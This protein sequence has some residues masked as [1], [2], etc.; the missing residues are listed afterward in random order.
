ME[1]QVDE[2][3]QAKNSF[4]IKYFKK[5]CELS[6]RFKTCEIT[7]VPKDQNS[8]ANLFSK[9]TNTKNTHPYL[10]IIQETLMYQSI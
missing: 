1:K 9:L 6:K 5:V 2:E 10:A 8:R 4:L 7:Y 3:Y